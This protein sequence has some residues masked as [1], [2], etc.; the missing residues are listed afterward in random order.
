MSILVHTGTLF[1]YRKQ[2][3]NTRNTSA[4]CIKRATHWAFRICED[5]GFGKEL[6][7]FINIY[8]D[9][10]SVSK[11]CKLLFKTQEFIQRKSIRGKHPNVLNKIFTLNLR[12]LVWKI[13]V[14]LLILT[15]IQNK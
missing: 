2:S 5:E 10:E 12:G 3:S 4:T 15:L 1:V 8:Q 7:F 6:L 13:T 14:F 9:I 11:C